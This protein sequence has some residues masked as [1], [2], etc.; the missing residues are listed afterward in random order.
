[1]KGRSGHY[2]GT[3]KRKKGLGVKREGNINLWVL[4]GEA[5]S[6]IRSLSPRHCPNA[7]RWTQIKPRTTTSSFFS[8]SHSDQLYAITKTS[9]W[10]TLQKYL[11]LVS[12]I[13]I[14]K[15]SLNQNEGK[16]FKARWNPKWMH[17]L[18]IHTHSQVPPLPCPSIE[19]TH[20]E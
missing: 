7:H 6:S 2:F 11:A 20:K 3:C 13:Q 17:P 12:P 5:K 19:H 4:H 9:P 16:K 1:M 14:K 8:P 18:P 10:E 15:K